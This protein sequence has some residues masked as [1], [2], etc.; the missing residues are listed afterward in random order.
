[1]SS[2]EKGSPE[3]RKHPTAAHASILR[4][5]TNVPREAGTGA[6]NPVFHN[7]KT[8]QS[9]QASHMWSRLVQ[10]EGEELVATRDKQ[11]HA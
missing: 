11:Y 10:I 9:R 4:H 5:D 1:M 3:Q 6:I 8:R 2:H 7:H